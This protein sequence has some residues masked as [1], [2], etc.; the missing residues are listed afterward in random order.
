MS[1]VRVPDGE[2]GGRVLRREPIVA[3]V[4]LCLLNAFVVAAGA[5][6]VHLTP[7]RE[8]APSPPA[9]AGRGIVLPGGGITAAGATGPLPG[10]N[11]LAARLA[12]PMRSAGAPI[13]A[14]V[15]DP[16]TQRVLYDQRSQVPL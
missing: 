3:V 1:H 11:T 16:A 13:N 4:T 6:V 9:V 14:V 8:L 5:A 2:R 7:K 15:M 12:G 10:A